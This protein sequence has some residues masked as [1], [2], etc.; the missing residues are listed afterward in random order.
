MGIPTQAW[1]LVAS[2]PMGGMGFS[3]FTWGLIYESDE[4]AKN[5]GHI[6]QIEQN[7][8]KYR[9]SSKIKGKHREYTKR[10]LA[11]IE[12]KYFYSSFKFMTY[13]TRINDTK[14]MIKLCMIQNLHG[15][16]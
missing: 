16:F 7:I 8:G 12:F 10:P 15:T 9:A 5:I 6:G 14:K 4:I 13:T 1:D 2:K 3:W 11:G